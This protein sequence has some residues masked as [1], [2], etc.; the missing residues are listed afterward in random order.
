MFGDSVI[1][2]LKSGK[3]EKSG[4]V[5]MSR[6]EKLADLFLVFPTRLGT[7]PTAFHSYSF[8]KRSRNEAF[9]HF[10]VNFIQRLPWKR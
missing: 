7:W 3:T 8:I 9:R 10:S 6:Q 1:K 2:S 4:F 5:P